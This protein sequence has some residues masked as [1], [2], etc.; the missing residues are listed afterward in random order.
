MAGGWY[1]GSSWGAVGDANGVMQAGHVQFG[2]DECHG[3]FA[4]C[5]G[6]R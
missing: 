4:R 3:H 2:G 5:S 1:V 6:W